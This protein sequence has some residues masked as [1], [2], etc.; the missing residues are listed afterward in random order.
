M[1]KVNARTFMSICLKNYKLKT[2]CPEKYEYPN[3]MLLDLESQ[4]SSCHCKY[5]RIIENRQRGTSVPDNMEQAYIKISGQTDNEHVGISLF[6]ALPYQK[7]EL[8][9]IYAIPWISR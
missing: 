4:A 5:T 7:T 6:S 9:C 8:P 2:S 3:L 1:V